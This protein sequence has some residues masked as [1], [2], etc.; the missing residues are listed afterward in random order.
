MS[1]ATSLSSILIKP[2]T[3]G[4]KLFVQTDGRSFH[5]RIQFHSPPSTLPASHKRSDLTL[6]LL[7]S[8]LRRTAAGVSGR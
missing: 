7:V 2:S 4:L 1:L 8:A 6:A 3:M 5:W